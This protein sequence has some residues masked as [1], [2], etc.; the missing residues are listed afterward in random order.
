[1]LHFCVTCGT[2]STSHQLLRM[3]QA[4]LIEFP[5]LL[6]MTNFTTRWRLRQFLVY[7]IE[8]I[9]SKPYFLYTLLTKT[10]WF[11]MICPCS[12]S[13]L[14]YCSRLKL[15][16]LVYNYQISISF[17]RLGNWATL[18]P[19]SKCIN[20]GLSTIV[21]SK[22]NKST[23]YLQH[24]NKQQSTGNAFDLVFFAR[25]PLRQVSGRSMAAT[26]LT[27]HPVMSDS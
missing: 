17:I 9:C 24:Y 25:N 4:R 26:S 14:T 19:F 13:T 7:I 21:L 1:M 23:W 10:Y 20:C 12:F 5:D 8:N 16:K 6:T 3:N 15:T 11:F 2:F 22:Q 27:N 18:E